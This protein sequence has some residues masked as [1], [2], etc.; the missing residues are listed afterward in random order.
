M[1]YSQ[2]PLD[3]PPGVVWKYCGT[4]FD[5]LGRIIE[6]AG[7]RPYEEFLA[8]RL[9][10]PLGMKDTTFRPSRAQFARLATLYKK[11][12]E[13]RPAP[14]WCAR[15]ARGA[16]PGDAIRY[17]SPG[18]GLYS[19]ASDYA[20]LLQMLLDG[21]SAGGRRLLRPETVAELSKI[22]FTSKEKVG[23]LPGPGH[24]AGGAGG[25]DPDRRHRGAVA[26]Q[27]RARRGPRHPGLGRP[28]ERPHLRADDPAAGV[29]QRRHVRRAPGLPARGGQRHRQA[30]ADGHQHPAQGPG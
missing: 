28:E 16:G 23:L 12:G 25:D 3:G 8:Q 19:T 2:Q 15:R 29:R 4:A 9:F 13:P 11:D 1:A 6:V 7:G 10:R 5:T 27:L 17:P 21:G 18:G 24:G 30:Q 14:G 20:R 26:G 22:H